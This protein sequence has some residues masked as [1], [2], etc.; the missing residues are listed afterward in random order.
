MHNK[1]IEFWDKVYEYKNNFPYLRDGQIYMN[2]LYNVNRYLYDNFSYTDW[3][4]F[5][6]D[7][8]CDIFLKKL[9]E[10]YGEKQ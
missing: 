8:L 3:D 4:C 1:L 9:Y 5:Y 10:H 2:S 6:D 7:E